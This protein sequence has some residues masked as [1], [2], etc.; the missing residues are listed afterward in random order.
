M[1]LLE[2]ESI[3][4]CWLL[5]RDDEPEAGRAGCGVI[6][7]PESRVSSASWAGGPSI[8]ASSSMTCP[9]DGQAD[10]PPVSAVEQAGQRGTRHCTR[11]WASLWPAQPG[12]GLWALGFGPSS[13]ARACPRSRTLEPRNLRTEPVE[14]RNQNLSNPRTYRTL[15]DCQCYTSVCFVDV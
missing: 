15:R 7:A 12:F 4:L 1:L 8:V 9:Q 10:S 5:E 13:L 6:A 14:P 2:E 3:P 11:A